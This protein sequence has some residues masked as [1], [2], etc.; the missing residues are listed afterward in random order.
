MF[1]ALLIAL[2]LM[3][4]AVVHVRF[5]SF[6]Y[7]VVAQQDELLT[8]ETKDGWAIALA[9]RTPRREPRLPPVLLCHG[10]ASN[11]GNLDFGIDRYSVSLYL[12]QAGFDCFALDLRG[13]GGSVR[14]R[15]DAPHLWTFDTYLDQDIP[16]ALDEIA[17][18]TGSSRALWVG[19]SQGALLGLLTA[20]LHP[21]RIAGVVAM[22]PPTHWHA[23][24]ELKRLMRFVPAGRSRNRILARAF[25][26]LAGYTHPSAAQLPLNTRNVEPRVLRQ[27]MANVVEDISAGVQA[28]FFRWARTDKFDSADGAIDYRLALATAKA[29]ALFIAGAK[30]LLAPPASV[31]AGHDLWGGEKE[32]W[33]AGTAE[34]QLSAN[35]GHSDLI[36]GRKAPEEIFA[37]VR[38]W[39]LA[40]SQPSPAAPASA[41]KVP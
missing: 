25:S 35:Y 41:T 39:L 33:V 21:E 4:A 38:D 8:V 9:R 24:E 34:S 12:A 16:A 3:V 29:P 30:D 31:R 27:V 28:Q 23:Q 13:H 10:L 7:R 19:H 20:S 37:R 1:V 26:P 22:A 11:R 5:W 36:Y 17:K 14:A 6:V 18:V 32:L 2:A 40:H 15:R